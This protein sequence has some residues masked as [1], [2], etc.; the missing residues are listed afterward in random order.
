MRYARQL[1]GHLIFAYD[2]DSSITFRAVNDLE[3]CTPPWELMKP[4]Q[5]FTGTAVRARDGHHG[6]RL[7]EQG[8]TIYNFLLTTQFGTTE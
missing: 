2:T 4:D 6:E 1:Q 8:L 7:T 5:K 3:R